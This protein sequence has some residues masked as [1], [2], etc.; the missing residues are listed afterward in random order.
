[1]RLA[2]RLRC[3]YNKRKG[4]YEPPSEPT[5]RRLL[6][7]VSAEE[8]DRALSAWMEQRDPLPLKQLAVDGKVVKGSRPSPD[9]RKAS[10][11][12]GEP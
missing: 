9:D 4:C 6:K 12:A 10:W 7:L 2:R 1:M 5:I 8:F 3:Y 11:T